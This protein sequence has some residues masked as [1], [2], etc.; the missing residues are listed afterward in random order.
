M[1]RAD[2][3]GGLF[4]ARSEGFPVD[5]EGGSREGEG[6]AKRGGAVAVAEEGEESVPGTVAVAL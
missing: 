2:E 5:G 1:G 6:W 3:G 4:V